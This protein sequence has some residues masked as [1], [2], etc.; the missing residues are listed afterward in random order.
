MDIF[1]MLIFRLEL[2]VLRVKEIY[3]YIF[4]FFL[5]PVTEDK[6][7]ENGFFNNGSHNVRL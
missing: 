3:S 6:E 4:R 2:Y 5:P 7:E 1:S